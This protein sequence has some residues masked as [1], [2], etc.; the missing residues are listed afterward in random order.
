ME[1]AK[2]DYPE[3]LKKLGLDQVEV[4]TPS[5]FCRMPCRAAARRGDTAPEGKG[6]TKPAPAAKPSGGGTI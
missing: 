1:A 2:K 3:M 5:D 4:Q 6:E